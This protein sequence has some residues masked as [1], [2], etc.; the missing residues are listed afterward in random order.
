[1]FR[2]EDCSLTVG[3][4]TQKETT[5]MNPV[6]VF[7]IFLF[8]IDILFLRIDTVLPNKISRYSHVSIFFYTPNKYIYT[9]IYI[10]IYTYIFL[11]CTVKNDHDF[12]GKKLK[13]L[14]VK[15]C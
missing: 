10:Y 9:Y 5:A 14:E 4:W 12:N 3:I 15:T 2:D 11:P 1:M 13:M 8:Y 7:S 6:W